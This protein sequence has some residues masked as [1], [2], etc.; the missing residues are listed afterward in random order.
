[1]ECCAKSFPVKI[2]TDIILFEKFLLNNKAYHDTS[3]KFSFVVP[4]II[5]SFYFGVLNDGFVAPE[6][7]VEGVVFI[8]D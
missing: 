8:L 3:L 1:M 7:G 5:I 2:L 6:K 4:W